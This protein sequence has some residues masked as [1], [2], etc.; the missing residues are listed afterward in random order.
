MAS[1]FLHLPLWIHFNPRFNQMNLPR[2]TKYYPTNTLFYYTNEIG[3]NWCDQLL[4]G[5]KPLFEA[6]YFVTIEIQGN[7]SWEIHQ[8]VR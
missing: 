3:W 7:I 1:N 5:N 4:C 2:T 8:L 6:V